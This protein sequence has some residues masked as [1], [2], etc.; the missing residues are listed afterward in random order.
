MLCSS[1]SFLHGQTLH[2]QRWRFKVSANKERQV[3]RNFFQKSFVEYVIWT[4][5][6]FKLFAITLALA[7]YCLLLVFYDT[8]NQNVAPNNSLSASWSP[9]DSLC[10]NPADVHQPGIKLFILKHLISLCKK[11]RKVVSFMTP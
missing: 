3:E 9:F 11:P 1:C 4:H 8:S 7:L 5:P 6:V 2:C 10:N